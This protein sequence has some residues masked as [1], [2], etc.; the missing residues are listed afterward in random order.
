ME[1]ECPNFS[2]NNGTASTILACGIPAHWRRLDENKE[3]ELNNINRN[4]DTVF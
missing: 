4:H 3:Q 2:D 1:L